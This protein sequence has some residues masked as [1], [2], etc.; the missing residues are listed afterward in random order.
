[1]MQRGALALLLLIA[2]PALA[3]GAPQEEADVAAAVPLGAETLRTLELA[4]DAEPA[5]EAEGLYT[6]AVLDHG[7]VD[8]LVDELARRAEASPDDVRVAH[9][10]GWLLRRR[11]DLEEALGVYDALC[12]EEHEAPH[13]EFLRQRAQLLDALGRVE[14]SVAAWERL[15]EV[16]E[17]EEL[18][19]RVRL[20]LALLRMAKEEDEHKQA[21]ADFAKEEGRE[22]TLRNRAAVVL[23]L[24]ERPQDAIELYQVDEASEKRFRQEVRVAEWAIAA[25]D[26]EKAQKHAWRAVFAAKLK[27]DRHYGLTILVEAH[28]LDDSLDALIDKLEAEPELDPVLQRAWI[29]LL[30]ERE[31]YDEA[32]ALFRDSSGG[33]FDVEMRRELLEMYREAGDEEVML[34]VYRDLIAEEPTV[35]EWREGLSRAHLERGDRAAGEAVWRGFIDA[36]ESLDQRLRG[37]QAMMDL[38]LDELAM[39][40]AEGCIAAGELPYASLLFLFGLHQ[41]RGRLDQA[42]ACLLRMGEMAPPE[43]A[44]RYQ[45]ADAWE[46][47]DRQERAIEVLEGVRAARPADSTGED[48]EMRLAWLYSEVG[49]EEVALERWLSLWRRIN[50]I[51]RRRYAEDRLMTVASRLGSLADIAIELERKLIEG[52]ADDRES[53][54]LV[55]LY[56]KVGDPVSAAEVI[57]EFFEQTGG[58]VVDSLQEKARVYLACND[59]FNY[60]EV[61]RELIEV[62]PEGEGDYLR[63]L[64]MSQLERGK[65]D[66]ARGVLARLKELEMGTES[67]EF[68]AGVLALAGLRE[69]AIEAYRRG[70]AENPGRI[71]SYLLMANLM[72]DL[73][74]GTRAIG[75]FQHLAETAEQDD[76]FTIAIDGLLN[77]E[78][79]E[80]VLEWARRITLERLASRHDKM[81][82]YQLLSDLAEQVESP[83]GMLIALENSLSIAGERRPSVLRELMDI[84]KGRSSGPFGRAGEGQPEKHL[85]YG[86][87]LIGLAEVVPP[88]VYLD[89]GEAFLADDDAA[90][91]TKTFALANDLPDYPGFQRQAAGLF[92]SAGF[93]EEALAL[94]KRV[95]VARS[96]DVGLMV[97][98]GELEEQEGRDALAAG[99]YGRALELLFSRQP[100]STL[101]A[102]T[103]LDPD[104]FFSWYGAR[105]VDDFDKHYTRLLKNTLVVGA[106]GEALEELMA[107]QLAAI[108]A[109]VELV[110]AAR[111]GDDG[112]PAGEER[113]ATL[114]R[115]PRLRSRADYYRRLAIAFGRA[116]LAD[117]LDLRLLALF[118]ED[119]GL[120]E[121]LCQQRVSWGLYGSIRNLLAEAER[122]EKERQKLRFLVGEGLD[123]RSAR[124]LP[125]EQ[126]VGLFLPLLISGKAS[127]ASTLILRTDFSR[128]E[129]AELE[130]LEP[131]FSA[132]I[133][134]E[135][136]GLTLQVAREWIRLHVKHKS[137][138]FRVEPVLQK[139][140]NAL[141]DEAYRNLC[142]G[143]TDQVLEKPE[144]TS[145]FLTLL[146]KLQKEFEEPLVTEEQVLDL[147]DDY[148]DG[149]WGFGLGPV[150][151]LLPES[152][153]GAAM[154]TIW[155]KVKPT[156]RAR[157]LLDLVGETEEE[158][159]SSVAEF[160]EGSFAGTLKEA[161]RVYSFYVTRI[162]ES[163][164]NH[165]T[166][167]VMLDALIEHKPEDWVA[168]SGRAMMLLVLERREEALEEGLAVFKGLV[169]DDL[170]DWERRQA[171]DKVLEKFL[172]EELD[173]FIGALDELAAERGDD[174]K[175]VLRRIELLE[176]VEDTDGVRALLDAAGEE[177]PDDEDLLARRMRQARS[178]GVHLLAVRLLEKQVEQDEEER[179]KLFSRWSALQHSVNALAVKE[180]L[181]EE[182]DGEEDDAGHG[183]PG[184]PAGMILPAGAVIVTASGTFTAGGSGSGKQAAE[185]RPSIDKVKEAV[186]EEDFAAA[187]TQLRRLWRK[188]Q[189][190][191]A[192]GRGGSVIYFFGGN[193]AQQTLAWPE[194]EEEEEEK[195]EEDEEEEKKVHRGGLDSWSDEEPEPPKE[196]RNAYEVLA[197]YD[198][199]VDEMQRLLRSK[200]ARELDNERAVFLGL[201]EAR[202][203]RD[204][205]EVTLEALME[206][207]TSGRADKVDTTML[208]TLLDEEPELQSGGTDAVL[209]DLIQAVRPT[210][211]GPLRSLA[212]VHARQGNREAARRLYTWCATR[213]SG[214]GFNY[215]GSAQ[216]VSAR[217][218]VKEVKEQLEGEDRLAVID[219]ILGF[220]DPGDYPW[221]RENFDNLI[222]ETY[223]E[224]LEPAEAF[225]RCRSILEEATDFKDG[226]RRRTALLS[227]AL[228]AQN[229]DFARALECFEYGVCSLP[230]DVVEGDEA[231]WNSPTRPGYWGAVD[232]KRLFPKD[233][234][235][236]S[237]PAG[238]YLE[239][240]EGL[241]GWMAEDRVRE[242]SAL[243]ALVIISLRL[244]DL[245][246]AERGLEIVRRLEPLEGLTAPLRL[247]IADAAREHGDEAL[248]DRIERAQFAAGNLHLQRIP[249]VVRRELEEAGPAAALE[250][251]EAVVDFTLHEDLLET[252]VEA[253]EATG[254]AAV[255]DRWTTLRDEATAARAR[256]EEIRE[257]AKRKAEEKEAA[258]GQ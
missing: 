160:I 118:P 88:Q 184:M 247:W 122:P 145:N 234:A 138:P 236:F 196:K 142:L 32:I 224:L 79:P 153:R 218:L 13:T 131:L 11:G 195:A 212:R 168:R 213:T 155:A 39:E 238:W 157:F 92:E 50:S 112:E 105:N 37:A 209:G 1:M 94:Y 140:R 253:A 81:Y 225:E 124:R 23:G 241:Q 90:S 222:L 180:K 30:R 57:D 191:E 230:E 132:S 52:R 19:I 183:I 97:K 172:P 61:V 227:V 121:A 70:I 203:L 91:A 96:S 20:R 126:S 2:V 188:F 18:E 208:L 217:E 163:K 77:L 36:P 133:Y 110:R 252:L 194:D 83:D 248:A 86:R 84:A 244:K 231:Y 41:D 151:T 167:L 176:K 147:L 104:D 16:T 82:L 93:R 8:L 72:R 73:G 25:E 14:D 135:D 76:L 221:A 114:A 66:E 5:D 237:D 35:V 43:A 159:G 15:L 255:L 64:A 21:L 181:M 34:A 189:K 258:E 178:D 150:I 78:A 220:A 100:L 46:Q 47:L 158:L 198:F 229:G 240:A 166:A 26:A 120:L 24:S 245:D 22:A 174:P 154:R 177:F 143:F 242:S 80:P 256:L 56:T 216:T 165:E 55:R 246:Q 71:E 162:V 27:R 111:G 169:D 185:D 75:V 233:P 201:L 38:G 125:L 99:L 107:E 257:E 85:A 136:P 115:H 146:P 4:L 103:T 95:L 228:W 204:G 123:E 206:A 251:G 254:D 148:A 175:L 210:D 87:R 33:E 127:E 119:D 101:E 7:S 48:L 152:N 116:P 68:E 130:S 214:T 134:L 226:L 113:R 44:E 186:D 58:S 89:L 202:V 137:G 109:D 223:M 171:R 249:E 49:Q 207:V 197:Q 129:R 205:P 149:G 67:L 239:A 128:V 98:V 250:M 161:D 164:Y 17:E 40:A 235:R 31:R 108:D 179:P 139:C 215:F 219:A 62:D 232:I 60:E 65:P 12:G 144:E 63:Q 54:L 173:T 3:T 193:Q 182:D 187:R 69:E 28:R 53:G 211:I 45:L 74:Q 106:E 200:T 192:N 102:G 59:Y 199:G 156:T 6:Q 170:S 243:Q 42:E 51:A 117:A 10:H 29:G 141:D 9:L 190:G